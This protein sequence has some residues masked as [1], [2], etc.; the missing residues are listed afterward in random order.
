M[1]QQ[2]RRVAYVLGRSRPSTN[3]AIPTKWAIAAGFNL[4]SLL[5]RSNIELA[6]SRVSN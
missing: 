5:G 6:M 3:I 1:Y 2:R 4:G